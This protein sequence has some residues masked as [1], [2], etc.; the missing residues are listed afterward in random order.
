ML[1]T[2]SLRRPGPTQLLVS[3][4]IFE[5]LMSIDILKGQLS[6]FLHLPSGRVSNFK[7]LMLY[8]KAVDTRTVK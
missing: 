5:N 3:N 8:N 2:N 7:Q 4:K 6:V 1:L